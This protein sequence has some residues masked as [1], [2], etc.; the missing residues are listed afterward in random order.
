MTDRV[1][2]TVCQVADYMLSDATSIALRFSG[3]RVH[4]RCAPVVARGGPVGSANHHMVDRRLSHRMLR[5]TSGFRPACYPC[6][7]RGALP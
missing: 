2:L 1:T 7:T 5:K 3:L 6:V 4:H